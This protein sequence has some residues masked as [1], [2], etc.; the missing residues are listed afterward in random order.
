MRLTTIMRVLCLFT[1]LFFF[2]ALG[3]KAQSAEGY[4]IAVDIKPYQNQWVYL[5]YHYG[6]LKGLAD[7][8]FLGPDSKGV[9]QGKEPLKPGIYIMASPSKAI[10]FEL[11]M[12]EDQQFSLQVDTLK[13]ADGVQFSGSQDNTDFLA[14]TQFVSSKVP[15]LESAKRIAG[16]STSSEIEKKQA[17]NAYAS[18]N[19]ALEQYRSNYVAQ[20]PEALL[21]AIFNA[22]KDHPAPESLQHP[23]TRADSVASYRYGKDHYWD[24]IDLM[25]GRLVRTPILESKLKNYLD[26]WVVP[27]ADSVITEFNWMIALGRNDPEMF[28]YLIGYY[29]DNYMYPKVMGQ[30]KVFLHVYEKYLS[31]DKPKVDWLNEKQMKTIRERAMMIMANQLGSQGWDMVL[32]DTAGKTKTLYNTQADYTVIVFWDV[33]C[34]KCKEEIPKMDTLYRTK[35]L[36]ENVKIYAVMVNEDAVK[37]WPQYI[38]DHAPGWVH[39]HQPKAMR[40]EEEKAG[41]PNFRQLYDMRSTPTLFLLD[42]DKNI[43]AKSLGLSDLDGLLEQKFKTAKK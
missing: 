26:N 19:K 36:K 13:L 32:V 8:A 1:G 42:K 27:D 43:I 18:A 23:T 34:G 30:D 17:E 41:K 22:M 28:K 39:V 12:G 40:D 38:R 16:D 37:E 11:L 20:H 6:R 33:H 31:G 4:K 21:S 5:A 15:E 9:F 7:S 24:D 14:Y 10:L 29:V 2:T 25:D 3:A 35:W